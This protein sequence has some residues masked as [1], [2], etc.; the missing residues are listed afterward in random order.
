[1]TKVQKNE[2]NTPSESLYNTTRISRKQIHVSQHIHENAI[3]FLKSKKLHMISNFQLTMKF[4]YIQ[5]STESC[6]TKGIRKNV[7]CDIQ[8]MWN[9]T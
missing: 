2:R 3:E 5:K 9:K 7:P 8:A 6:Y 4:N 1:M